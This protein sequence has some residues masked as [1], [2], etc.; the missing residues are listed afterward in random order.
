MDSHQARECDKKIELRCKNHADSHSH[1]TATCNL[2]RQAKGLPVHPYLLRAT[3]TGNRVTIEGEDSF[4]GY[5]DNSVTLFSDTDDTRD[6]QFPE[7]TRCQVIVE[8]PMLSEDESN[9]ASAS[10]E[11]TEAKLRKTKVW[12]SSFGRCSDN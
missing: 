9:Y 10:E 6:G 3:H 8:T 12:A 5:P 4:E 11:E 7:H 1:L 2:R